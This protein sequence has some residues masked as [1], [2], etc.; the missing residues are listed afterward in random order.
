VIEVIR[1]RGLG[2]RT[3]I[4]FP[5]CDQNSGGKRLKRKQKQWR[6][7]HSTVKVNRTNDIG[8]E[9]YGLDLGIELKCSKLWVRQDYIR[10]YDYCS[11]RH[12]EGPSSA[13][14]MARSVVITGQ[15]GIGVFPS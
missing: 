13:T 3:V 11:K 1:P 7:C 2:S 9:C 5:S 14:E 6:K 15:P 12:A 4:H 8:P 10:I